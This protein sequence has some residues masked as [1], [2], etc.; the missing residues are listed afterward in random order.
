MLDII[1]LVVIGGAFG[2]MTREFIMLMVPPLTDGFPL[3]ILVANV[4]ACFLL[5]TV[6]ALYAKKIHSRDV[7]TIIGTGMMGGVST[8]SSF[9]YGSVVLASASMSAFLIAA[10][11]VTVSVV[12]GYV[13]VLA[14]MKFG[15]K[16]ADIL[17]RYPPMA[18]IIDS[19]LVTVESRHS[20]AETIERVAAKAK[21]MGMNVFTR[22]D[23]GAG[24][25]EA[26]LGL[27]PTE[28]IIFGN[29]QNGTVLM[30]DKRTIGLDLPIRALAWE[31]GN[32]KVWLTVNDPAW[33]AQRHSLGLS[34]DVAVK[35]M[36]AGTD[37]VTKYATGD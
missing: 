33:L 24:A 15:E 20:V 4:V 6:T 32:G 28:L 23:H 30:E 27:Q 9:A 14:G 8:F 2:A 10:A 26:G 37:T 7:H 29:P 16:S 3:D 19:G 17:H 13:A 34:S 12:A 1:I 21:S 11:Y 25:K 22:V 31:D 35:A 5:G 18:S 36:V